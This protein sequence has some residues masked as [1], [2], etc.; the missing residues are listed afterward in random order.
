[1]RNN[2]LNVHVFQNRNAR[3]S[4]KSDRR[5]FFNFDSNKKSK[6]KHGGTGLFSEKTEVM[7]AELN[8][9]AEAATSSYFVAVGF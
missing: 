1:M 9:R 6:K 7:H 8:K 2:D 4:P 5:F 3:Y